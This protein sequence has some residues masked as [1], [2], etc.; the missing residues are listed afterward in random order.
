MLCQFVFFCSP[1][2]VGKKQPSYICLMQRQYKKDTDVELL[3]HSQAYPAIKQYQND[4]ILKCGIKWGSKEFK[5]RAENDLKINIKGNVSNN[6][7]AG[8][9]GAD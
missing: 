5:F 6:V 3:G 9:T 7:M 1:S 4:Q 2:E 8:S